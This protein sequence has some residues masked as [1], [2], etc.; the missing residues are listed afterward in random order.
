MI[1]RMV[2]GSC[3]DTFQGLL[4]LLVEQISEARQKYNP[5]FN[6]LSGLLMPERRSVNG[7]PDIMSEHLLNQW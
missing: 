5:A 6:R 1:F 7:K 2:E 4:E 3:T